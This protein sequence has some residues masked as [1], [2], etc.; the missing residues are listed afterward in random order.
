MIGGTMPGSKKPQSWY[1]SGYLKKANTIDELAGLTR[2]DPAVLKTSIDRF[3]EGARIGRDD[4]FK[5]GQRAYDEWLG[6][7]HHRPSQTLGP[8]EQPPFYAAPVVPGDV[9]TF[10]GVVTDHVARVL[11]EDGTPIKG[12]YATGTTTASVMGRVYPGAGSSIGPS[13]VWGYVA[14]KHAVGDGGVG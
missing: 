12:L 14:A 8:I 9:G 6:D 1:D 2:I 3:N 4:E 5:R 7:H 13:F 11:R 10:G